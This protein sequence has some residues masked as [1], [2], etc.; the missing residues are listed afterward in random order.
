ARPNRHQDGGVNLQPGM[1]CPRRGK[2]ECIFQAHGRPS[3]RN[4]YPSSNLGPRSGSVRFPFASDRASDLARSTSI[5]FTILQSFSPAA[6]LS[7][8][9]RVSTRAR[10]AFTYTL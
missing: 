2:V 3:F 6:F 10:E 5:A 8:K 4:Q 9:K 1:A 7:R